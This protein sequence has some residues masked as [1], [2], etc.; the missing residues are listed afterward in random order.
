[1][2]W[3]KPCEGQCRPFALLVRDAP[4]NRVIE[5]LRRFAPTPSCCAPASAN[6]SDSLRELLERAVTGPRP[7]AWFGLGSCCWGSQLLESRENTSRI[8]VEFPCRHG[9]SGSGRPPVG[10]SSATPA[11]AARLHP[12]SHP[13]REQV[14]PIALRLRQIG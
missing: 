5:R 1:V 14:S 2:R 12:C 9:R 13:L 8:T 4:P 10:P 11:G 3:A 7:C 6:A